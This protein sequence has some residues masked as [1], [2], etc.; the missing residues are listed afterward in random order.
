MNIECGQEALDELESAFRFNDAVLR[1][2]TIKC[3]KAITEASPLVKKEDERASED[4][5]ASSD[6][7]DDDTDTEDSD[8]EAA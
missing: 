5:R 3:D 1:H 4:F 8:T 7:D 2:L 6:N